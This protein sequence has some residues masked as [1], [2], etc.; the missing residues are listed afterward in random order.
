MGRS[1]GK[2]GGRLLWALWVCLGAAPV[3][4]LLGAART[5]E[6]LQTVGFVGQWMRRGLQTL[7]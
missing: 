4:M 7:P 2:A 6:S 5:Q 1:E 3:Q